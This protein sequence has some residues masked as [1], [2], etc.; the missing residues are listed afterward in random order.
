MS[1][2]IEAIQAAQAA[3][4]DL[5][6]LLEMK[7][8]YLSWAVPIIVLFLLQL[9]AKRY[10]WVAALEKRVPSGGLYQRIVA[11]LPLTVAG[12]VLPNLSTGSAD[13]ALALKT[14]LIGFGI[15]LFRQKPTGDTGDGRAKPSDSDGRS[16]M[17]RMSL[18][19]L[20]LLF[21]PSCASFKPIVRTIDNL[22]KEACAMYFGEQ[23]GVSL[24]D[25]AKAYCNTRKALDPFVTELLKAQEKAGLA[26][27]EVQ[28]I[29]KA[30]P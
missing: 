1:E 19:A 18:V 8:T 17:F 27:S 6:T 24:E 13:I 16:T 15:G 3:G 26:S 23:M 20:V 2:L 29:T 14:A 28:G 21:M 7:V 11:A 12:A 4:L 5:K 22:A 25:A 10:G 9:L 30:E